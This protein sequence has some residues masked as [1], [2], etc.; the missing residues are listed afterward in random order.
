[1][2][3]I[4]IKSNIFS[5]LLGA[6]LF[7]SIGI[8]SAYT[9][10]ANDIGYT[11]KDEDWEVENVNDAIDDLHNRVKKINLDNLVTEEIYTNHVSGATYT[12]TI[13]NVSEYNYYFLINITWRSGSAD[14]A[15]SL[16][17]LTIKT[18]TNA[19]YIDYGYVGAQWKS[20]ESA[21]VKTY[22][23]YP[24]KSGQDITITLNAGDGFTVYGIKNKE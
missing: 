2:K 14:Y 7:G 9:I 4:F 12:Y 1:M 21:A 10:F 19:T 23:I 17:A 13:S 15:S 3:K 11:S 5:F 6:I 24:D 18:I 8:V 16:N 20:R 22:L